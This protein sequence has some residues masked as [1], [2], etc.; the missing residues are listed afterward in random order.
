MLVYIISK[1]ANN[2]V[3]GTQ[4]TWLPCRLVCRSIPGKSQIRFLNQNLNHFC[5]NPVSSSS[6]PARIVLLSTMSVSRLT[7]ENSILLLSK[8]SNPSPGFH[9]FLM[10]SESFSNNCGHV[11][12]TKYV[13]FENYG[14]QISV[15]YCPCVEAAS[16]TMDQN[17]CK[18][19][20]LKY[21]YKCRVSTA[22]YHK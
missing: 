10:W 1:I 18:K 12:Y 21:G 9:K 22:S 6:P 8:T 19:A 7:I 2:S 16:L 5:V 11:Y 4:E 20:Q 14:H 3:K 15:N 17:S 13:T